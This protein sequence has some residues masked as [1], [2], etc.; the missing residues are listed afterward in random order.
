L[1]PRNEISISSW[2]I[3]SLS[4]HLT[5]VIVGVGRDGLDQHQGSRVALAAMLGED[6]RRPSEGYGVACRQYIQ[7]KWISKENTNR[8]HLLHVFFLNICFSP[9][10][11]FFSLQAP[12]KIT[13]G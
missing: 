8:L 5:L 1:S 3:S 7:V 10:L 9:C 6:R 12:T 11:P 4:C 13:I 2:S